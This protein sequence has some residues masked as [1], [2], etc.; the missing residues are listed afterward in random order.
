MLDLV[1]SCLGSC[2][3]GSCLWSQPLCSRCQNLLTENVPQIPE[4]VNKVDLIL[5]LYSQICQLLSFEFIPSMLNLVNFPLSLV[6]SFPL[7]PCFKM[8]QNNL[9]I[10]VFIDIVASLSYIP[11]ISWGSNL[12][13]CWCKYYSV[14]TLMKSSLKE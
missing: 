10:I 9:V 6:L 13:P 8:N 2:L 1:G 3:V 12:Q 11:S 5:N 14:I 7:F 4:N